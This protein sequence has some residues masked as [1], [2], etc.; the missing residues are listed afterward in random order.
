MKRKLIAGVAGVALVSGVG[1]GMVQTAQAET[2][3]P[4]AG[5][6]ELSGET[7]NPT[8]RH[9]GHGGKGFDAAAL[10]T[11]LGL[12]AAT[13]SDALTAVRDQT[14]ATARP[15]PDATQAERE[16][17]RDARRTELAKALAAELNID[18]ATVTTA[19]TQVQSEQEAERAAQTKATL[20]QAV[21]DGTLTQTEA[22]AV[23]KALAA[24]IIT[25]RDG[26]H[27]RR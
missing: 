26:G 5:S 7:A 12:P 13:V 20:D 17:A 22:D 14:A 1:L 23:Q 6:S 15:S 3:T 25:T 18:E 8:G 27:G 21:T 9:D 11:K 24:H 10:A 2:P 4:T 16:V 19:L